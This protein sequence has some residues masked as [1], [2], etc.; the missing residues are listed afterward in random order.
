MVAVNGTRRAARG[1]GCQ[2]VQGFEA[3]PWHDR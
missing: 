3:D 2:V 1:V